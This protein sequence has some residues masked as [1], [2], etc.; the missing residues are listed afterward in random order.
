[1]AVRSRPWNCPYYGGMQP[2]GFSAKIAILHT[3]A[4][5]LGTSFLAPGGWVLVVEPAVMMWM[6][7]SMDFC[8]T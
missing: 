8:K 5:W 2:F 3:T 4:A 1:M 6:N 7:N